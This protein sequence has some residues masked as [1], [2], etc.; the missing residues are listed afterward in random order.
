[1]ATVIDRLQQKKERLR[2]EIET[3][4]LGIQAHQLK[5]RTGKLR[6]YEGAS[7]SDRMSKWRTPAGSGPN[8]V[9]R[10][11]LRMLRERSR[12]MVRNNPLGESAASVMVAGI[13]G[14]GIEATISNKRL[15]ALWKQWAE[16]T[17]CD[18]GGLSNFRGLQ[19]LA[20]RAWAENGEVLFRRVIRRDWKPGEIPFAIQ[21]LEPDYIDD[22]FAGFGSG[23][24]LGVKIDEYGAPLAYRLFGRHPYENDVLSPKNIAN[25]S[26]DVPI[27]EI[28]HMFLRRRI[29]QIRGVPPLA[30]VIVRMRDLD[31][32]EDAQL[33]RQ[34]LAACFMA[35]VTDLD[36]NNPVDDDELVDV[37][38]PGL[39]QRLRQGEHVEF[40][41][42]PG[43]TGYNE[44][45]SNQKHTVSAGLG[46]PY[47]E[48]TGDYSSVS[49]SS[50]RLARM[51]FYGNLDVWQWEMF[52]PMFCEKV[53]GWFRDGAA[54]LGLPCKNI[55]AEWTA[56]RRPVAD[57]NEY[58]RLR[59]EVRAGLKSIPEAIREN[60][61]NP[62]DI[63]RENADFL[64]KA[65]AA[66]LVLDS[67]PRRT[68]GQ[69]QGQ[70]FQME[71]GV[72]PVD[73]NP[74]QKKEAS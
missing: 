4:I 52:I 55:A 39:V 46:I 62:D 1:M 9:L 69:G 6:N 17:Q 37:L 3:T 31:E 72:P 13:V 66:G 74:V 49:W 27:A 29:G 30:P 11:A 38:E 16:S 73:G 8:T 57:L 61:Y 71:T 70:P 26:V 33:V 25:Q 67:D 35:F 23:Y 47:E 2:L 7:R 24:Q 59:D 12:D 5:A 53:F 42:P 40:A 54:M 18:A 15:A 14:T 32:F 36:G 45:T 22:T 28:G 34:K 65:D 48:Y 56:P 64:A 44:Y 68:A 60:G 51:K 58:V 20:A 63:I 10:P 19:T 43:V 41:N 50:G 21:L